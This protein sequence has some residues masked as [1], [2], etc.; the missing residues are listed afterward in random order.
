MPILRPPRRTTEGEKAAEKQTFSRSGLFLI[1]HSIHMFL[2][3]FLRRTAASSN[4][5]R[6]NAFTGISFEP[7]EEAKQITAHLLKTQATE[8]REELG[9]LLI[10][11]LS[12]DAHIALAHVTVSRTKQYHKRQ[13]T[14][15]VMKRYGYYRPKS[16]YIYIQNRTAVRGQLLAPK[17]FVNTLLHEWMHHYDFKQLKLNSIHTKGFYLRLRFLQESLLA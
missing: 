5:I 1:P 16:S 15:V 17:T 7:S 3:S 12:K 8:K 9:N 11:Q 14:R 4:Y 10:S 6:S 13:G 2:R